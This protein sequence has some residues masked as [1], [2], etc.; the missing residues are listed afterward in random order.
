MRRGLIA[1]FPRAHSYSLAIEIWDHLK[2]L[3][4]FTT[5]E[6]KSLWNAHDKNDQISGAFNIPK[7][8]RAILGEP[9]HSSF[10]KDDLPF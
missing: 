3:S 1:A 6:K 4:D 7:S 2:T 9:L 8:M 5:D 10:A